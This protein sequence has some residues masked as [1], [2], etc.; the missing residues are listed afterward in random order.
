MEGELWLDWIRSRIPLVFQEQRKGED[1]WKDGC[2]NQ[3]IN[4][5]GSGQLVANLRLGKPVLEQRK[6]HLCQTL[7]KNK[8][9]LSIFQQCFEEQD[10][11]P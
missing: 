4:R 1:H 8:L 5:K 11:Y 2:L 6:K 3:E 10:H 9:L 7:L